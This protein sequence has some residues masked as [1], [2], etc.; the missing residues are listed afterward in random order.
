MSLAALIGT[1]A[2]L[3]VG[4]FVFCS[5]ITSKPRPPALSPEKE[6]AEALP[7]PTLPRKSAGTS[8]KAPSDDATTEDRKRADDPKRRDD[9]VA[10]Q[11][12]RAQAKEAER[13]AEEALWKKGEREKQ[14]QAERK[15]QV[16]LHLLNLKSNDVEKRFAAV[17][18]LWRLGPL[19]QKEAPD[20]VSR[21]LP[22]LNDRDRDVRQEAFAAIVKIHGGAKPAVPGLIIA[23]KNPDREVRIHAATMLKM[24][25]P[26]AQ[27]AAPVLIRS[28]LDS[29]VR[30][31]ADE[32]LTS[33]GKAA[34]PALVKGLDDSDDN[35]RRLIARSLGY[36]GSEAKEAI[37]QLTTLSRDDPSERVREAATAALKRINNR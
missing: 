21:L 32:A 14:V 36:I 6:I 31:R 30:G 19:A 37:P 17:V 5:A 1:G 11:K 26:D 10:K 29:H 2:G 4:I 13:V 8:L 7:R 25:G 34:V 15:R 24:V 12:D 22:S 35:L 18:A 20:V 9:S 28:L 3:L 16:P 27:E 23:L 33:I